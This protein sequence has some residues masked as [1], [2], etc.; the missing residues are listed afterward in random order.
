[1]RLLGV[2]ALNFSQRRGGATKREALISFSQTSIILPIN[3]AVGYIQLF[4]AAALVHFLPWLNSPILCCLR[5]CMKHPG[6]AGF[7]NKIV[8]L[9][10]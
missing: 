6:K 9:Q 5:L 8:N 3:C 4:Q 2:L 10:L 7:Q 1:L